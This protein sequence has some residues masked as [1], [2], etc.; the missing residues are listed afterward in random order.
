[1]TNLFTIMSFRP[2]K[3]YIFSIQIQFQHFSFCHNFES[4]DSTLYFCNI[5]V[6]GMWHEI[7]F[8][9][10]MM[11]LTLFI[12]LSIYLSIY[13]FIHPSFHLFVNLLFLPFYSSIYL[14]VILIN[15]SF[16]HLL[17]DYIYKRWMNAVMAS[18]LF[19]LFF[20]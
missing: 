12:N 16:M 14:F 19:F 6:L 5:A 4:A 2:A 15:H 9:L 10:G 17:R 13:L 1:M 11:V 20:L 18:Q 8:T 3:H 7:Q